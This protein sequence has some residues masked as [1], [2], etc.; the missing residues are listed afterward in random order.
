MMATSD[1]ARALLAEASAV[2]PAE[3]V[4]LHRRIDA[5]FEATAHTVACFECG[6]DV[7]VT[8]VHDKAVAVL[9]AEAGR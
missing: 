9:Q 1:D 5:Y 7:P 4:D 2:V 6:Q 3:F 8:W